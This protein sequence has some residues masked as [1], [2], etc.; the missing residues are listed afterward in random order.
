M[1]GHRLDLQVRLHEAPRRGAEPL[2]HRAI[3]EQPLQRVGHPRRRPGRNEQ[4][5]VPVG[6]QLGAAAHRGGDHGQACGHPLDHRVGEAFRVAG[7]D[8]DFAAGE[9]RRDVGAVADEVHALLHPQ[10]PRPRGDRGTALALPHQQQVHVGEAIADRREA[11]HH[12]VLPLHRVEVGDDGHHPGAVGNR[13]RRCEGLALPA[14]EAIEVDAVEHHLDPIRRDALLLDQLP[15][16]RQRVHLHPVGEPGHPAQRLAAPRSVPVGEVEAAHD[17]LRPGEA[18]RRDREQ[19]GVEVLGVDELHALQAHPR[20]E[21]AHRGEGRRMGERARQRELL[22]LE[23]E[24]LE[25]REMRPGLLE[26]RHQR[27][28]AAEVGAAHALHELP[29]GAADP[30]DVDEVEDGGRAVLA[31]R[32]SGSVSVT[33]GCCQLPLPARE[34]LCGGGEAEQQE[35]EEAEHEAREHLADQ[36]AGQCGDDAA[37]FLGYR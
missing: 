37:G 22:R 27:L 15:L 3:R 18:R 21:S 33:V 35:E 23:A 10:L 2:P 24:A 13:Q 20:G 11:L 4:A 32:D 19:V 14:V 34:A 25:L 8:Q 29:L 12:V 1:P 7:R 28:P 36:V 6:D 30:E 9:D 17:H 16:D 31:H 5:E 26:R